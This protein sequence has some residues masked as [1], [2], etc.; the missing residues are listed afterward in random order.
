MTAT[1]YP[2]K[3]N[4]PDLRRF[5]KKHMDRWRQSQLT[6]KE[7]CRQ[8]ELIPHRFTYWKKRLFLNDKGTSFVP[9]PITQHLSMPSQ[10][11]MELITPNGFRIKV[12]PG[13]DSVTLKQLV[14]TVQSL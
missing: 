5:W 2:N 1:D 7:Y 10:K 11:A 14:H 13:F 6:Q 9:V 4:S 3:P 12:G 8:N